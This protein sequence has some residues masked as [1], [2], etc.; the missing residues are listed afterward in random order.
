MAYFRKNMSGVHTWTGL[1][2]GWLLLWMFLS[3]SLGYFDTEIDR[4]MQPEL[5][6]PPSHYDEAQAV[7]TA[8]VYLSREAPEASRWV[9]FLPIDRNEPYLRV[10]WAGK[11]E[12]GHSVSDSVRLSLDTG[13]PLSARETGGGQLLYKMHWRLHYMPRVLAEF[14]TGSAAM[15]MLIALITGII[16]HKGIF[17]DLFTFRPKKGRRSWLD[18]HNLVAVSSLPFQLMITYSGLV[19]VMFTYMPLIFVAFYGMDDQGRREFIADISTTEIV[20]PAN[21]SATMI[22]LGSF[23]TQHK[24]QWSETPLRN[25]DIRFPGDANASVTVKSNNAVS[26]LRASDEWMF[27][28]VNGELLSHHTANQTS[29]QSSHDVLLGLHEGL[30]APLALRWLYFLSGVLGCLMIATGMIMWENKRRQQGKTSAFGLKLISTLNIA[31]I[32]GMPIC[33]GVYFAANRLLP[34]TIAA[35]ADWEVHIMF[36]T[37]LVCLLHAALR[38]RR[39]AWIEQFKSAGIV[40]LTLPVLGFWTTR[41]NVLHAIEQEDWTI[42]GVESVF[43]ITGILFLII[44]FML[45]KRFQVNTAHGAIR[46][47]KV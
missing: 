41:L 30:F 28:A 19:F 47:A 33:I 5:P 23:I 2:L 11:D 13:E 31:S 7:R 40:F 35:R 27:S 22:D 44:A 26:P 36:I 16:I 18:L 42:L 17:R 43:I 38:P 25:L 9:I 6:L 37:W 1:V 21:Q 29:V 10:F 24:A 46:G 39:W 3:G 15:L 34:T 4:W 8:Q 20:A 14:I 32:A 12:K 45:Y